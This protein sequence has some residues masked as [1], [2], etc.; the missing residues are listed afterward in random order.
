LDYDPEYET[1]CDH[2][3]EFIDEENKKK[4]VCK[5]LFSKKKITKMLTLSNGRPFLGSK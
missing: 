2:L 1:Q 3:R 4:D 5:K